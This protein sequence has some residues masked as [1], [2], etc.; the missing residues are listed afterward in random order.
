MSLKFKVIGCSLGRTHFVVVK[1][2]VANEAQT[3]LNITEI[4]KK[5]YIINNLIIK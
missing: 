3:K 5:L 4:I 2:V 1:N